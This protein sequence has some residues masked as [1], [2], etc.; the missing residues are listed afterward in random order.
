MRKLLYAV[1]IEIIM[2]PRESFTILEPDNEKLP[3]DMKIELAK[4]FQSLLI[5]LTG[6]NL[7][8]TIKYTID[9][10]LKAL[11]LAERITNQIKLLD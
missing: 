4:T 2:D 6:E 11:S 9:D 3:E 1:S 5:K 10:I 8:G 7:V